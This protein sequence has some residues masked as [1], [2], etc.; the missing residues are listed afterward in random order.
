MLKMEATPPLNV[1]S[2]KVCYLIIKA[3]EFEAKDEETEPDPGSNPADDKMIAVLE[4]HADDPVDEEL[5]AFFV[6]LNEDEQIDL[7]ALAWLGRD[8][9]S[10]NDWAPL[11]DE[12]SR[13]HNERTASYLLGLPLLPDYLEEALAMFGRSCEDL[14]LGRL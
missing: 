14:E 9:D 5:K 12:A 7:V 11:R 10:L 2:D 1:S 4:E 3:R 13:A 8:G 6:G